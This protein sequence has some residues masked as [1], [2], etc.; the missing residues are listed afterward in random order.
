MVLGDHA[1]QKG[2]LV[3]PAK[4]RFDF[5]Q[6]SALTDQQLIEIENIV[7]K[8][9]LQNY[10]VETTVTGINE[11]RD[12][13]AMALFGE[14]YG[15]EVRVVQVGSFSLELCGGAHVSNTGQIGLFKI[16]SEGSIGSG[17]RRIEALTGNQ[18]LVYLN[19][20]ER[21]VK[22]AS[23]SLRT[24]PADLNKRIDA[25]NRAL[26]EKEKEVEQLKARISKSASDDTINQA[27]ELN[28][29]HILIAETQSQDANSLRQNAEMLK[30]KLGSAV[31]V[32]GSIIEDKVALVCFASKDLVA[33][34]IHAGKI[35]GVAAQAA[36][37]GGGGRP[38][39]AQAGGKDITKLSQALASAKEMVE[40]TL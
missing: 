5:S 18:A 38:D 6:L 35:I 25:L 20:M 31:V 10:P 9:I 7:N 24:T 2:S 30:D 23:A 28:G 12:M 36:G 4:L 16:L 19:D 40:K 26:K 11:A 21:E 3:E 14:K 37:G 29:A 17:L 27:Y 15:E 1:Q 33:R 34:G 39:M 22:A 13:G 8:A 32:L